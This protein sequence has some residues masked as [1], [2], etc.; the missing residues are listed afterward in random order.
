M[1]S[2]STSPQSEENAR[3]A[4]TRRPTIHGLSPSTLYALITGRLRSAK[5]GRHQIGRAGGSTKL[6]EALVD[7]RRIAALT[8]NTAKHARIDWRS[9]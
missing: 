6:V 1:L 7:D 4:R 9:R 3:T 8:N 2:G 5:V